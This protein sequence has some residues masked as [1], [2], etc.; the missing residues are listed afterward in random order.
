[1]SLSSLTRQRLFST[2]NN[3][4][5]KSKLPNLNKIDPTPGLYNRPLDTG[6]EQTLILFS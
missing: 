4:L 5:Q 1:M 2:I 6:Q 3:F